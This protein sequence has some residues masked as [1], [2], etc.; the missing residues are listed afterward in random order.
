MHAPLICAIKFYFLTYLFKA[1]VD[2]RLRPPQVRCCPL[3]SN[4]EYTPYLLCPRYPLH[5]GLV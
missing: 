3:V 1:I 5:D 4:V 2:I